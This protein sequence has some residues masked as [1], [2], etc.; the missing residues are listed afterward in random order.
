MRERLER[1]GLVAAVLA[2][3][4]PA[5]AWAGTASLAVD[6]HSAAL[7]YVAAPGEVNTLVVRGT[8]TEW[9]LSD[10][11]A[12]LT[13]GPGCAVSAPGQVRCALPPSVEPGEPD[14]DGPDAR[15]DAGDG[16]DS[17]DFAAQP[18]PVHD[19]LWNF[20]VLGGAGADT[21]Q[22]TST[23]PLLRL[24]G[25]DGSDS[26]QGGPHTEQLIGGPGDDALL[27]GAGDDQL[28]GDAADASMGAV[29][30]VGDDTIDGGPGVDEVD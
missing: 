3:L 18:P 7:A 9:T 17:V 25:G 10:A 26:V 19:A 2:V 16:D 15:I 5:P 11:T 6:R 13:A 30:P 1:A 29:G 21:L 23:Q 12:P 22:G 4:A 14:T 24:D 20:T 28:W 8:T 27:G